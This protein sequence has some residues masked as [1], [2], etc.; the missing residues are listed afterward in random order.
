[1]QIS[2]A[3]DAVCGIRSEIIIP[4]CPRGRTGECVASAR[5]LSVP[6]RN[7]FVLIGAEIFVPCMRRM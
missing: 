6:T 4:D 2:S 3:M 7:S 1:M 5:N